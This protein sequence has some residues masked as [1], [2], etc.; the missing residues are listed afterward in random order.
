[1]LE[2]GNDQAEDVMKI[3]EQNRFIDVKTIKDYG[4]NDRV[5]RGILSSL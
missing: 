4:G 2:I 5:V 3:M 1:L